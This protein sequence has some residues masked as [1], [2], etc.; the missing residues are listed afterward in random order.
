MTVWVGRPPCFM[1]GCPDPAGSPVG[2]SLCPLSGSVPTNPRL[3]WTLQARTRPRQPQLMGP[4]CLLPPPVLLAFCPGLEGDHCSACHW[5]AGD[6]MAVTRL[7][8]I[9]CARCNSLLNGDSDSSPFCFTPA[10]I[11]RLKGTLN[12]SQGDSSFSRMEDRGHQRERLVGADLDPG[13]RAFML[14]PHL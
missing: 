12:S 2:V 5:G 1:S 4:S 7:P 13:L 9:F 8:P 11:L 10:H 3:G 6:P 14:H